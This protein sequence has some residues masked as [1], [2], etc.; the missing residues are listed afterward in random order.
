MGPEQ[1]LPGHSLCASPG[2]IA[3]AIDL[4]VGPRLFLVILAFAT[5]AIPVAVGATPKVVAT[6]IALKG[7]WYN[8]SATPEKGSYA[9][10]ALEFKVSG[11]SKKLLNFEFNTSYTCANSASA[12]GFSV[13]TVNLRLQTK[14]Y[15][16]GVSQTYE[17]FS[18]KEPYK[19]AAPHELHGEAG[20]ILIAGVFS[21]GGN[22]ITGKVQVDFTTA[23]PA[24]TGC[25]T[26]VLDWE[27]TPASGPVFH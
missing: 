11:D 6:G 22:K 3:C 2:R 26:G 27:A 18:F 19:N 24:D 9:G 23:N 5:S 13:P 7:H 1:L 4:H 12:D 25:T 15:K 16:P 20:T 14:P 21:A 10:S 17:D 8:G